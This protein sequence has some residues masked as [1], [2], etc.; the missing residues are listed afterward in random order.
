MSIHGQA[1]TNGRGD[2]PESRTVVAGFRTY[3]EAE[4]AV[5][6]LS[7]ARFPVERVAI[8]A[9][10]LRFVEQVTGRVGYGRVALSSAASGAAVGALFGWAAG[11]VRWVEPLVT[12]LTLALYGAVLGAVVGLV[13]G[14]ALHALS[15]GR[16]DF[17]ALSRMEAERYEVVADA[18]V[19]DDARR[20]LGAAAAR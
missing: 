20:A 2:V 8:V 19:A 9:V 15:A 6:R 4:R 13:L 14:L 16:R 7:E 12:G 17:A 3:A 18:E 1:A 5:S 10:G 11:V